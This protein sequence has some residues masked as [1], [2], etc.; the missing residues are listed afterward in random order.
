MKHLEYSYLGFTLD[1]QTNNDGGIVCSPHE[2]IVLMFETNT[3]KKK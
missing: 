1:S 2:T 3:N